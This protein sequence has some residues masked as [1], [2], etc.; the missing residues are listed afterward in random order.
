M[1]V[2]V[3]FVLNSCVLFSEVSIS[4]VQAGALE[5]IIKQSQLEIIELQHTVD[6]LRYF[7]ST[8]ILTE[9]EIRQILI[10]VVLV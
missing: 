2:N 9:D 6:E 5:N 10:D 3:V 7:L 4:S 1:C 8:Y